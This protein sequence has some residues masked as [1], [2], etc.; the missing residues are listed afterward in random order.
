MLCMK[1]Y[2][3]PTHRSRTLDNARGRNNIGRTTRRNDASIRSGIE[4]AINIGSAH[5]NKAVEVQNAL[6]DQR[7]QEAAL[8][9]KGLDKIPMDLPMP[10]SMDMGQAVLAPEWRDGVFGPQRNETPWQ[11]DAQGIP[12]LRVGNREIKKT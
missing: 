10:F 6:Y 7:R 3:M 11:Y 12:R 8:T 5:I 9:G 2:T 1:R 4:K